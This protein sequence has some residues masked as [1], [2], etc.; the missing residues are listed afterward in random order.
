MPIEK[1]NEIYFVIICLHDFIYLAHVSF[2]FL[3]K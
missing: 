3:A 2:F 1:Q